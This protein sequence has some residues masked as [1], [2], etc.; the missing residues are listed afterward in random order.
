MHSESKRTK[1]ELLLESL[2]LL[3]LQERETASNSSITP[4]C[5]RRVDQTSAHSR[6]MHTATHLVLLQP[7]KQAPRVIL[8]LLLLLRRL[9]SYPRIRLSPLR[10]TSLLGLLERVRGDEPRGNAGGEGGGRGSVGH[11]SRS[12]GVAER[13]AGLLEVWQALQRAVSTSRRLSDENRVGVRE[14][15]ESRTSRVAK[16]LERAVS[17]AACSKSTSGVKDVV[18]TKSLA[19]SSFARVVLD[20]LARSLQTLQEHAQTAPT[21]SLM[22]AI[23]STAVSLPPATRYLTLSL[24]GLSVLYFFVHLSVNPRDLKGIFGATGDASLAFPWLV[25]VPGNVIWAPWT[26]LTAAF[27]ETNFPEVRSASFSD[28]RGST[29][30]GAESL[31][32]QDRSANLTL[33]LL[34]VPH[35][36]PHPSARRPVSRTSMGRTRARQ[37]RSR[38]DGRLERHCRRRQRARERRSGGLGAVHVRPGLASIRLLTRS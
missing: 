19:S 32:V 30:N 23:L 4:M 17:L 7:L 27:V 12:R 3:G 28:V 15:W 37:V 13:L 24:V 20:R 36:H 31:A 11:R 26:L 21:A 1:L 10:L 14:S 25:L 22:P 38:D 16:S 9:L 35:L 5:A 6:R 33:V 29:T 18:G 8:L 2:L 34:A